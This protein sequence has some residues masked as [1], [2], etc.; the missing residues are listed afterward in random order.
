MKAIDDC[1][2]RDCHWY[3][4]YEA[5]DCVWLD[6][7]EIWSTDISA[8]LIVWP[9][10]TLVVLYITFLK[11][12]LLIFLCCHWY[13]V[14]CI[15]SMFCLIISFGTVTLSLFWWLNVDWWW[16]S[17][18]VMTCRDSLYFSFIMMTLIYSFDI[19]KRQIS[20]FWYGDIIRWRLDSDIQW[21]PD[22]DET[23]LL[24]DSLL[25]PV[26]DI[27]DSFCIE[28]TWSKCPLWYYIR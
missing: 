28:L 20:V 15:P 27:I 7:T 22:L 24:T 4:F 13:Y 5:D 2:A 16:Q 25:I 26:D 12:I 18:C 10:R 17:I 3:L 1:N 8:I 9:F 11:L 23:L 14:T 6:E 19:V 21:L